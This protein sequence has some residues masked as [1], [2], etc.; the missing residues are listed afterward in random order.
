MPIFLSLV[1]KVDFWRGPAR[2]SLPVDMRVPFSELTDVKA[3]LGSHGLA[4]SIMIKDVQVR[5]C[6][7]AAAGG[8]S[9]THLSGL[10]PTWRRK[11]QG[12]NGRLVSGVP[13]DFCEP[14]VEGVEPHTSQRKFKSKTE[15]TGEKCS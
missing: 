10:G 9:S 1:N 13:P 4:Y 15:L 7:S 14:A 11:I 3:Y 5:S 6:P 12:Y 2:P 8:S